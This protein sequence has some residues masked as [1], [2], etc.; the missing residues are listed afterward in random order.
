MK[1]KTCFV[2]AVL[3]GTLAGLVGCTGATPSVTSAASGQIDQGATA[4]RS[5]LATTGEEA[6]FEQMIAQLPKSLT[7][8]QAKN[9]L[10]QIDPKSVQ[11]EDA[12]TYSVQQLRGRSW[13]GG[14]WRGH[15]GFRGHRGFGGRGFYGGFGRGFG[16]IYGGFGYYPNG[17]YNFPYYN[18]AGSYYP[19]FNRGYFPYMYGSGLNYSPSLY[20]NPLSTY[21]NPIS[22]L[23]SPL[24]NS[25]YLTATS[26]YQWP[27]VQNMLSQPQMIQPETSTQ[28]QVI[29]NQKVDNDDTD[30][31]NDQANAQ[32]QPVAP[33]TTP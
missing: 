1:A 6:A 5:L 4:Q 10:I 20:V 26:G 23:A 24:L 3:I 2:Q 19:F 13:H 33:Q 9:V 18:Y 21:I 12:P 29:V 8:E 31:D 28:P 30:D 32:P 17:A 22:S 16:S 15:G 14:G 11:E 27:G 7:A 25:N